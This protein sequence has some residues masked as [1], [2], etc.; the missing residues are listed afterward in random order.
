MAM[1]QE[2]GSSPQQKYGLGVRDSD[3][4]TSKPTPEG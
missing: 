4:K 3:E 1:D 2:S